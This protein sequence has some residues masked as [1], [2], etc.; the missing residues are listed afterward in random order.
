M[1]TSARSRRP[2]RSLT[3]ALALAMAVTAGACGQPEEETTDEVTP[4]EV[5]EGFVVGTA[6]SDDPK[7]LADERYR[8][9]LAQNFGSVTPDRAFKW[10]LVQ[11]SPGRF[12]WS[13]PDTVMKVAKENG[14]QVRGHALLWHGSLPD[15][16]KQDANSC[17]QASTMLREHITTVVGRYRGQIWH[18]DVANEIFDEKGKPRQ[19]N[20]FVQ[21]CGT[22]IVADAFRWAHEADPKAKLYLNDYGT[23]ANGPKADAQFE[24][25][26]QLKRDGVPIHGVGFQGHEKARAG[27]PD[28]AADQLAR[29][30][31]LDLDVMITEADVRIKVPAKGKKPYQKQAEAYRE[32]LDVCLDQSRCVAFTVWSFSD[33]WGW[34]EEVIEGE[35]EACLLDEELRARPAWHAFRE[36]L[37]EGR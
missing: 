17:E 36:R 20:P 15:W 31:E 6:L 35:G 22:G 29:V 28:G 23:L 10:G 12:D 37:A 24:L 18:W 9:I 19:E 25:V 33:R 5:P 4:L 7:A 16:V 14:Q 32:L 26:S 30:A 1:F 21:A 2:S 8:E 34:V 3:V 13:G 11:G 27:I